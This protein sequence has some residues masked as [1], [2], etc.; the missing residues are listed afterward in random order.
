MP[1]GIPRKF[2]KNLHM[3]TLSEIW[4]YPVKSLGGISLQEATAEARGLRYDR[5][6]M[7]TDENG[8]FLTQREIPEMALLGTA[9]DDAF[10][11][12]FWKNRPAEKIL[13]PLEFHTGELPEIHVKVWDDTCSAWVL[14]YHINNWLSS[15]LKHKVQLV[16]MPD[17]TRRQTDLKYTTEGEHV[18][19]A[20]G[21]PFL[22]IGQASLD[23]LN[24]RLEVPL[25]MN[26]FRPNF[27]FT[28]GNPHEEDN[29]TDFSIGTTLFRGVKPCARCS[30]TTTDQETAARAAEPLK[31]L[32]TYRNEGK[33]I[34]FGQNVILRGG[35]GVVRVGNFM[36]Y[37][38]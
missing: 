36:S 29:W 33:K 1:F 20:D 5:R 4:I 18:S 7:I 13:V 28:G 25:P 22:V 38:L 17:T 26:R 35:D 31:M 21:Y 15:A 6:W 32:A 12:I 34:L 23:A 27:V 3:L 10:L 19:F 14:P 11:H 24:E 37:E 9:I 2:R 30:I 8:R 16:Y